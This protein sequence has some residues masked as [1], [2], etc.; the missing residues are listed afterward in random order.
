MVGDDK[1]L[2]LLVCFEKLWLE[3]CLRKTT[4]RLSA[5]AWTQRFLFEHNEINLNQGLND[6]FTPT[7]CKT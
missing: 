6:S 2:G 7:T 3:S 1:K 4:S 5:L